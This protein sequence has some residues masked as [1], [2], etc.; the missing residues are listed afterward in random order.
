[1]KEN[2]FSPVRKGTRAGCLVL[3]LFSPWWS[4]RTGTLPKKSSA[5]TQFLTLA[6]EVNGLPV[7]KEL[8]SFAVPSGVL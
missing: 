5:C 3:V 2:R 7:F 4:S 6:M 8:G 1:M